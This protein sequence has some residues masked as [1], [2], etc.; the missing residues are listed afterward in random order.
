[1]RQGYCH[2]L[3][4]EVRKPEGAAFFSELKNTTLHTNTSK[5]LRK[6]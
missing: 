1:L 3:P 2:C 5:T 4:P 6:L